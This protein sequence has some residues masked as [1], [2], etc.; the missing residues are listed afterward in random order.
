MSHDF[1]YYPEIYFFS[2]FKKTQSIKT[3]PGIDWRL[4][5]GEIVSVSSLVQ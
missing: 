4:T 1:T 3:V 5:L 2:F